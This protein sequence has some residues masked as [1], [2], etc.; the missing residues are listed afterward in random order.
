MSM[1][2]IGIIGVIGALLSIQFKGGKSE[3]GIYIS[4]AISIFIFACIVD[5]LGLFVK[6]VSQ[7]SQY[8]KIDT[9]YIATMLK[10]I[11]ITYIAEF[12][13]SVCKDA[14]YQTI[15]M[16]IEIFSKLTILALGLPVLLALL[17]TIQEFLS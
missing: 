2:Q 1:I 10:M 9:S 16:Q 17:E 14:G 15:A 3:Y 5:R 4:V 12:S 11:G 7:V 8:I 13:S 6:A